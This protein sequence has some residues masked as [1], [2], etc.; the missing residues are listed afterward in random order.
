MTSAS[1]R[2]ASGEGPGAITPDGCAVDLYALLLAGVAEAAMITSVTPPGGTVLEL[3]AGAG[4]V[5]Q[6]LIDGGIAVVA[7]DESREML[8]RITGAETVHSTIEMLQLGRRFDVVV[9]GSHLI[10]V[11]DEEAVLAL[12][13]ACARH[14]GPGGQVLVERRNPRWFDVVEE[15]TVEQDGVV[16]AVT[17]I[18]RP[19]P[20]VVTA[21]IT[22]TVDDRRWS[23]TFTTRRVDD[24]LLVDLLAGADLALNGF[25]DT[26]R[27][28]VDAYPRRS[29]ASPAGE[30]RQP[31]LHR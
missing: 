22:Y 23:Q 24:D 16:Y 19:A 6:C 13:R 5:T 31:D 20:A 9:L 28:W 21:T 15:T 10:N 26:D 3:G 29:V 11:P 8:D 4:R 12:L 1:A 7:V 30:R 2:F 17:V 14:V 27:T 25:L 18:E